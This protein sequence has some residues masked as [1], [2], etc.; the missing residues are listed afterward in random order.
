MPVAVAVTP[1]GDRNPGPRSDSPR[2]RARR[3]DGNLVAAF[4]ATRFQNRRF[5]SPRRQARREDRNLVAAFAATRFQTAAH[6]AAA[7]ALREDGNLV[8]AFA[9]TGFQTLRLD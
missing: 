5:D 8:A 7:T 4:A 9:A 1:G 2:R 3:E 6:R